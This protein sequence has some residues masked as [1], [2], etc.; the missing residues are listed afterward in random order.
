[1]KN[2]FFKLLFPK[3]CFGCG[4]NDTYLCYDCL[5]T[6]DLIHSPLFNLHGIS[7][8]Y[9]AADYQ[10]FIV[11]RLIK[12]Y[13]YPPL[14]QK[15]ALPL[16]SLIITH[17]ESLEKRPP[18]L[19]RKENCY[20][21]PVPLSSKRLRWRGFNQAREIANILSFYYQ[22]PL[23]KALEK[24]KPTKPQVKLSRQQ[25]KSNISGSFSS[26]PSTHGKIKNKNIILVDDVST[27][28]ATLS[29]GARVL[30]KAGALK[31]YGLV[32]AK[33]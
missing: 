19:G 23:I 17:L 12:K 15:L 25:R 18:F 2:N 6:I 24:K 7:G 31:I 26:P 3:K 1:M 28:G 33:D 16:A 32:A 21:V 13:K 29:E 22:I 5:S 4:Q 14:A 9:F 20:L 10:N 27:T 8:V 11:K 30:K